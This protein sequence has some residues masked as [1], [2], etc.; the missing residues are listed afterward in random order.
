LTAERMKILGEFWNADIA[1]ETLY[2]DNPKAAK[3][4]QFA[5]DNGIP[6]ILWIGEDEVAQG[7]VNVKSLNHHEQYVIKREELVDR[8]RELIAANPVLLTQEQ[9][10]ALKQGDS[11]TLE[12]S[13]DAHPAAG[14]SPTA[15]EAVYKQLIALRE[16]I[17]TTVKEACEEVES[18]QQ[19]AGDSE[20]E[21]K[22][23]E[24]NKKLEYRIKHLMSAIN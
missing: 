4:V 10:E 11:S 3:Q 6:L 15:S 18:K 8:V 21:K 1:A 24:K 16:G 9:Q 23:A 14:S 17:F 13:K 5:L 19:A 22:L 7:V 2:A 20:T 12:E